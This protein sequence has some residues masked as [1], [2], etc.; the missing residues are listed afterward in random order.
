MAV[1]D[2]DV[3][4]YELVADVGAEGDDAVGGVAEV[5]VELVQFGVDLVDEGLAVGVAN[6]GVGYP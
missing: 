4:V 1:G 6:S 3:A 2:G 5:M